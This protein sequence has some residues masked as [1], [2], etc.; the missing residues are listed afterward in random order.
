MSFAGVSA[1]YRLHMDN[2][3]T[4]RLRQQMTHEHTRNLLMQAGL[5]LL[6]KDLVSSA[7]VDDVKSF[8]CIKMDANFKPLASDEYVATV[9]DHGRKQN[10]FV[11]CL[12]WLVG[13]GVLTDEHCE[14]VGLLK[15]ERDR[16]AHQ[17]LGLIVDPDFELDVR[18]VVGA[19]DVLQRIGLYF[20][21]LHVD[22]DPAYDHLDIADDD[23]TS[24]KSV[25]YSYVL[26]AVGDL[27]VVDDGG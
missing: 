8:F 11:A 10:E 21:R 16:V 7:I 13:A 22:A 14:T 1:R 6:A 3:Y 20:G 18:P 23:I 4:T 15:Q 24:G 2:E 19:A 26:A 17:A 12:D 9:L 27:L 5:L 25:A